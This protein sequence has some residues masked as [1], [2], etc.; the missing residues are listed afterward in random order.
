MG[1]PKRIIALIL[2]G[3]IMPRRRVLGLLFAAS[4]SVSASA[5]SLQP[6]NVEVPAPP[7]ASAPSTTGTV[8]S[9]KITVQAVQ[10]TVQVRASEDQ[11]WQRAM[12]GMIVDENA[13]FRTS[14]RSAVQ[15]VIPPDQTITLDRLGVIKVVE[16]V[17][18]GGKLK[19]K[20]GM[21][22]GRTQFDI[23]SAGQQHEASIS[24]PS[25]TL[26]IRG[27]NVV[28]YDQRPWT[29]E[30][31]SF[32]GRAMF[33]DARK[34]MFV[35]NKGAGTLK[36]DSN[37][38][39][40]AAYALS[41]SVVDPGIA[42]AR[43]QSEQPLVDAVLSTGATLSYDQ[44]KGIKVITGGRPLTDAEL[45]PTLTQPLDFVL[46]WTGNA[47]LN[48]G[49]IGPLNGANN[50]TVYP[51]GGYNTTASGG[52]IEFDH[53]GGPHGGMEVATF[54]KGF[55]EGVYRIG[56]AHVS[57][58]NSPATV[59][60]FYQGKRVDIVNTINGLGPFK[61]VDFVSEPINPA[62]GGGQ[63]IGEVRL[64]PSQGIT[65]T[66]SASGTKVSGKKK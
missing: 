13:E 31:T 34:T 53:R 55:P 18:D 49:I 44:E 15:I 29:P 38:N 33:Q 2:Y 50:R 6:A 8:E 10:G 21:K 64:F 26:A 3:G 61:T 14:I 27:T 42:L 9:L 19:T 56:V 65:G 11:P 54:P 51:I 7:A 25:S 66:E 60:V 20:I 57:G 46:R 63:A 45:L 12:P 48:L 30:A 62:F 37:S 36:V 52:H 22:Y 4:L 58:V 35:G 1:V 23:E 5:L 39:S 40:S 43:S 28:L 41:Q 17:N 16:A 47:N 59:D 24:S 32:T